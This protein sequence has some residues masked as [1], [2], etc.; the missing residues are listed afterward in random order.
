MVEKN[1]G[2]G[3]GGGIFISYNARRILL[4]RKSGSKRVVLFLIVRVDGRFA[5]N[6]GYP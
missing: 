3:E 5:W 4:N 2:G 1:I 6:Y